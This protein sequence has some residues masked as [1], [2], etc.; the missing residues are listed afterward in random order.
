MWI[1]RYEKH[2]FTRTGIR[3]MARRVRKIR[4]FGAGL[5]VPAK[6]ASGG[7]ILDI[8]DRQ[9]HL[10]RFHAC[11][12]GLVGGAAAHPGKNKGAAE[13]PRVAGAEFVVHKSPIVADSHLKSLSRSRTLELL[14]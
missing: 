5:D 7:N 2:S 9:P 12:Q 3:T 13:D 14:P 6:P 1:T 10:A 4:L 8:T 11:G